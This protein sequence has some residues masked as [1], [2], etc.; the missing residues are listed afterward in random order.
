MTARR[1]LIGYREKDRK[2]DGGWGHFRRPSRGQCKSPRRHA[3]IR[4][5]WRSSEGGGRQ[6][7]CRSGRKADSEPEGQ[8]AAGSEPNVERRSVAAA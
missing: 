2:P 3:P 5:R 4:S 8:P 1:W 7:A 6:N